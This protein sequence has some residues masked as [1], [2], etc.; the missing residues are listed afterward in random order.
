LV[1]LQVTP[2]SLSHERRP[3]NV[4]VHAWGMLFPF[5]KLLGESLE[6]RGES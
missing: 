4:L 3:N 6:T 1:V 2:Q 5:G